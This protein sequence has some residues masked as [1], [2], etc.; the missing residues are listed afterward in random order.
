[1]S[2]RQSEAAASGHDASQPDEP[3]S[4]TSRKR[5]D[6][7]SRRWLYILRTTNPP[8]RVS[9]T[10]LDP[11]S[12]WLVVTRAAVLPMTATAGLI[13][14]L[15]AIQD[16]HVDVLD[17]VLAFVGILAAHTSNN[18]INDVTD[19]G[20]GNDTDSYP[21]TLYAPH[22]ILS[23]LVTT[24][25]LWVAIALVNL[26]DLAILVVLTVRVGWPVLAFGLGGF[27]L[28]VAYTVPPLRL[29][30]RGLGELDVFLTWGPLMVGGTYYASTGQLTWQVVVASIP[31][32]L[33]CT[34]VLMGK[35][36]D[37]I[38]Y[39]APT[40]TRTL[41]VLL[42]E[43]PSELVTLGMM[44]AYYPAIAVCVLVGALP[45]P[46]LLAVAAIP[47]LVK[48]WPWFLRSRPDEPPAPNPVWPLWFAPL[49]FLHT[50]PA[51]SLLV[52]GLAVSAVF[53][54]G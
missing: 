34:A 28:S 29:K 7:L 14:L 24:R 33:L 22:P 38:P 12:R 35:H 1:M 52:L 30:K 18:L 49:A 41:P 51:G 37:K 47:R 2:W 31:Y 48:I 25:Q 45:W 3:V 54:I 53:G 15:V 21:R 8:R 46:A 17:F 19:T 10:E 23:G 32:G 50:L 11:I 4:R 26:V 16:T 42:G 40:G 39:D 43:R 6:T 27:L 44:A 9:L 5:R 20:S 36:T 13:A